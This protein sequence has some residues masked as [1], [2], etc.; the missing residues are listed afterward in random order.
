MVTTTL[1]KLNVGCGRDVRE[2]YVNLDIAPLAG[3]TVVHD[4]TV[5]PWPFDENTFDEVLVMSVLEHLPNAVR[6]MEEIW[7]ICGDGAAIVVRVPHWNSRT[8][9]LD[10]THIR[11]FDAET[12]DFFDPDTEL[13]RERP[14]YS[15]AR[16]RVEAITFNGFWFRRAWPWSK[17]VTR[18]RPRR[19]LMRLLTSLPDIVHYMTFELRALKS[20][21]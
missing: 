11:P 15:Q 2:G 12:F 16:F 21:R 14:Y 17:R 3:V 4:L 18:E 5:F 7:R 10:P 13:C 6:T 8:A 19:Q 1:R 9:W 20:P